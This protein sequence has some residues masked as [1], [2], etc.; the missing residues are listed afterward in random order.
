M[1]APPPATFPEVLTRCGFNNATRDHLVHA[2]F[3][4]L[5]MA[6]IAVWSDDEVDDLVTT[7]RKTTANGGPFYVRVKA[8]EHL[9]TVC[10]ALR[11]FARTGRTPVT[12]FF[13]TQ[14]LD[15]W[16][17]ER[18]A[19]TSYE[20]PDDFPKLTKSDNATIFE[21]IEDFPE[22][23][24]RHTGIG[25]RPLACIIQDT[26]TVPNP[27]VDS[28]FGEADSVYASVREEMVSH[29]EHAGVAYL[30]DNKRVF[31]ILHDAITEFEEVK[32][33]IKGF[34]RAK[35]GRGAWIA[36]KAHYLGDAQLDGITNRADSRIENLVY[37]GEKARYN[38]EIHVSNF[39]WVH[40]DLAKAGNE[41]DGRSK[42]C[43][44]LQSIKAPEL[45]MAVGVVCSQDNLLTDFEA[46]INYLRRSISQTTLT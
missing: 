9:K 39:K 12:T 32:V 11:H 21:F 22:Q 41:P 10:Y 13:T 17:L 3:E 42:V 15:V 18:L 16:K 45:Q 7:L 43:K 33:W 2:D 36:F 1:A 6:T 25:G 30:A 31:E 14:A 27:A 35:D 29:P 37:H 40:L 19:E 38:F 23:L 34:V 46:C 26:V 28:I 5:D 20:D 4:A 8:Q 44:F 24:A